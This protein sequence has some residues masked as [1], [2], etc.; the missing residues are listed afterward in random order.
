[1]LLFYTEQPGTRALMERCDKKKKLKELN[2]RLSHDISQERKP[3]AR[4]VD[5]EGMRLRRAWNFQRI[6]RDWSCSK[7]SRPY[8]GF[9]VLVRPVGFV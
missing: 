7:G 1:M 4:T 8:I 3:Q 6:F 9:C 2:M 5:K